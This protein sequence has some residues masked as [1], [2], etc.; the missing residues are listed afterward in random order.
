MLTL[1]SLIDSNCCAEIILSQSHNCI[2]SYNFVIVFICIFI[3]GLDI[4][5]F[6]ESRKYTPP[7]VNIGKKVEGAYLQD[8]YISV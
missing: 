8:C 2:C 4:I 3:V 1:H 5:M 6:I 7:P